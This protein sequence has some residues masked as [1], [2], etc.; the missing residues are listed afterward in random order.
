M[1]VVFV[2]LLSAFLSH[3][4]GQAVITCDPAC[5]GEVVTVDFDCSSPNGGTQVVVDGV[6]VIDNG[7]GTLDVPIPTDPALIGQDWDVSVGCQCTDGA[8]CL[9]TFTLSIPVVDGPTLSCSYNLNC[10]T[11]GDS[12][13]DGFAGWVDITAD[14]CEFV[15]C[16]NCEVRVRVLVDG[17]VDNTA[18]YTWTGATQL[19]NPFQAVVCDPFNG[20]PCSDGIFEVNVIDANGCEADLPYSMTVKIVEAEL[21]CPN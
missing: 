18:T 21:L 15:V 10:D 16:D 4:F 6:S 14:N 20:S 5:L 19:S 3:A 13:A 17:V 8:D 12:I 11:D 9:K 1:R 2:F 7:D